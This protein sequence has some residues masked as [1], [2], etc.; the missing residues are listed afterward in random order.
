ML[1]VHATSTGAKKSLKKTFKGVKV[2]MWRH[3]TCSR[4][5]FKGFL[6]CK[7]E[8][9]TF[10]VMKRLEFWH[11]SRESS[12]TKEKTFPSLV[13][14]VILPELRGFWLDFDWILHFWC[15]IFCLNLH[16]SPPYRKNSA[17]FWTKS[18]LFRGQNMTQQLH[19][20]DGRNT[21]TLNCFKSTV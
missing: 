21:R 4:I 7:F 19:H 2:E 13:P 18:S 11:L 9:G 8:W 6:T 17:P 15:K 20:W 3:Q 1:T 12:G 5:L 16:V 10:K 14:H